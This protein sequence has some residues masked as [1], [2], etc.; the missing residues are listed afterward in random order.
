MI[1]GKE[2]YQPPKTV[3]N[4][5]LAGTYSYRAW[6]PQVL[7]WRAAHAALGKLVFVQVGGESRVVSRSSLEQLW[8][9]PDC[10]QHTWEGLGMFLSHLTPAG[11]GAQEA[12]NVL[13]QL[14]GS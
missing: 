2:K 3:K 11:H 10:H 12:H 6:G 8:K 5:P 13:C 14:C 1:F 9:W 4:G 7:H